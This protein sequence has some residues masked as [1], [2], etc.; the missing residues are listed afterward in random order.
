M[1]VPF[2]D[3]RRTPP[4][5]LAA[6]QAAVGR[7][8]QHRQFILGPEVAAFE[9][10]MSEI[11]DGQAA[12]GV[13]SGTDALLLA[14]MALDVPA[15]SPVLTTPFSFFATA[16]VIARLGARPVF[17]DID[18]ETY[19]PAPAALAGLGARGFAAA[20]PVHLFGNVLDLTALE[21]WAAPEGVPIVE[22]ACQ[23]LGARDSLGRA[24]GAAGRVAAYSFFPTKN[25][26]ALGDAGLL[27]TRDE[28]LL[29]RMKRLR[30]HGQSERYRHEEVGGNFRLDAIQA[31]GLLAAL[32]FLAEITRARRAN[33]HGYGERFAAAGLAPG[34]LVPPRTTPGHSFHQYV[35]RIPG[36]RRDA[37]AAGL[38]ARG[39]GSAVY[40]PIPLHL[41]PCF[42]SL[43]YGRGDF[44]EA[45]RAA[46]EVL[47][48][49]IFP[50]LTAAEQDSVVAAL[51][52]LV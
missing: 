29:Q 43:G 30:V 7:V 3:L 5:L 22:D 44:P 34:R 39:I 16:G 28:S 49:P 2:V 26:G 12:L 15:G 35:V 9:A 10:A 50:G 38:A 46:D 31:A 45:E 14:L 36:G 18:P 37:V 24:P 20:M 47:A 41:Q 13:S 52:E 6:E 25:L 1:K 17:V 8:L 33:A 19:G 48:L 32:P 4:E 27:S 40:Y 11:L 51:A 21:A 42:A 23:A